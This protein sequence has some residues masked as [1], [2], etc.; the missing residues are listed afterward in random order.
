MLLLPPETHFPAFLGENVKLSL[1][2]QPV[3]TEVSR[4]QG[5]RVGQDVR[6]YLLAAGAG[7]I[8][9]LVRALPMCHPSPADWEL[10]ISEMQ[11]ITVCLNISLL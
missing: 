8:L 9:P 4:P 3:W 7:S 2:L 11:G 5:F 10:K 6:L 1:P